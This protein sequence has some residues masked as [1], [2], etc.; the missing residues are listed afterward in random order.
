MSYASLFAKNKKAPAIAC[1]RAKSTLTR[2]SDSFPSNFA[3]SAPPAVTPSAVGI[4]TSKSYNPCIAYKT[5]DKRE[6]GKINK[7]AV[8]CACFSAMPVF[9]KSGTPIIPPPPPNRLF[10]VPTSPPQTIRRTFFCLLFSIILLEKTLLLYIME[11]F[12]EIIKLFLC[13]CGRNACQLFHFV[14]K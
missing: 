2:R 11:I 14:L 8:A 6:T 3:P 12:F 10:A 13:F 5:K 7:I 9:C 1:K 4:N